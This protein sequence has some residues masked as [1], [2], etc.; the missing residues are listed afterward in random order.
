MTT[1]I[2]IFFMT[3][4]RHLRLPTKWQQGLG[5]VVFRDSAISLSAISGGCPWPASPL[6]QGLVVGATLIFA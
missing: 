2:A 5:R 1:N 3:F 4:W 6:M